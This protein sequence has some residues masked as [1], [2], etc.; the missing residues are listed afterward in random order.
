MIGGI[1]AANGLLDFLANIEEAAGDFDSGAQD[2][3]ALAEIVIPGGGPGYFPNDLYPFDDSFFDNGGSDYGH[4]Y[5]PP[6]PPGD[7]A[8]YFQRANVETESSKLPK[9]TMPRH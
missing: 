7:W 2:M 5:K 4:K 9:A 1:L 3:A 8:S 6:L